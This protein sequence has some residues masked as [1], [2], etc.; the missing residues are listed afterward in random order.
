LCLILL[1]GG[2]GPSVPDPSPEGGP[3]ASPIVDPGAD[4]SAGEGAFPMRVLSG[5]ARVYERMELEVFTD[6][7]PVNPFDPAEVDLSVRFQPDGGA[8]ISVPA[9]AYQDFDP[10]TMA[11]RGQLRWL[12]RFVPTAPGSW[13]AQASLASPELLS[14]EIE[15]NVAPSSDAPGFVRVAGTSGQFEFDDGSQFLPIG[16]NLGWW[17][18]TGPSVLEYYERWL[19]HL[20][21]NGGTIARVWMASWSFGL[22]WTETGL[23]DYTAR[24]DRAWLLD[25]VFRMAEERDVYLILSILNHTDFSVWPGNGAWF[26]NPYSASGG[27]PCPMPDTEEISIRIRAPECF[28]TDSHARELFARQVRYIAARWAHST[29]LMSWEWWNEAELAGIRDEALRPWIEEMT[30]TLHRF[31][32]YDHLVTTSWAFAWSSTSLLNLPELDFVEAHV[33]RSNAG[34]SLE[35]V[36]RN[37]AAQA[38]GKPILLAEFGYHTQADVEAEAWNRGGIELHNGLWEAP[39]L[40]YAGGGMYW[41]WDSVV[42]PWDLWRHYRGPS[43]FFADEDLRALSPATAELSASGT[44]ALTL[45]NATRALVWIRNAA[46]DQP[47]ARQAYADAQAAGG[48]TESWQYDPPPIAGLRVTISGLRDGDYEASWFDP[49]TARWTDHLVVQVRD[50]AV[51]LSVPTL[52]TDLALRLASRAD[53]TEP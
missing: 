46:Y 53:P 36:V 34:R 42:E 43:I 7:A 40:G 17:W 49:Q 39:F 29:H 51:A 23:G 11:P 8:A 45:Q 47:H 30:A 12:V 1:A 9:F 13:T 18:E 35:E 4:A 28:L 50:G 22:E 15:F 3:A 32:P 6:L 21:A 16:V 31:D 27:G 5:P 26:E 14:S 19:D 2:C 24:L 33:Y 25:E 37:L 44:S 52:E 48:A 20:S 38:P 41:W 10:A